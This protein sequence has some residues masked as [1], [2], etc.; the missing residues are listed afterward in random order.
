MTKALA[1]IAACEADPA[2]VRE[3]SEAD[4]DEMYATAMLLIG[5][6]QLLPVIRSGMIEPRLKISPTGDLI[7]ERGTVQKLLEPSAAWTNG[8]SL[9][10]AAAAYVS[11]RS[12]ATTDDPPPVWDAGLRAA[13][14]AEY[15]IAAEPYVN[16]PHF[17]GRMAEDRGQDVFFERLS[18]IERL[19]QDSADYAG[20]KVRPLLDRLT[21]RTRANWGD[22]LSEA[23]RDLCRF[24]RN[25]SLISRPLLM[26]EDGADP[27]IL[28]AP[29]LV[30][31]AMMFAVSGLATGHLNNAFWQS[32]AARRCA[33]ER[34][35]ASKEQFEE[36]VAARLN[37]LGLSA[38]ARCKLSTVLNQKVDPELG[39]VDV[40]AVKAEH[41][42]VWVIEAKNLR[43][44]RTEP[45]VASPLSEYQERWLGKSGQGR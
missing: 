6:G 44:C 2:G 31:D 45:E 42:T 8:K 37:E 20:I 5:N 25:H 13:I 17:L 35:K 38:T 27:L 22:G 10:E 16:L 1:E 12:D 23:E 7:S 34:G 39:D 29:A 21:L 28:V 41:S 15:Q 36:T 4:L 40:L 32:D 11:D 14:E 9:D 30:Y 43:L 18:A 33:G 19:L 24:D 3:P 26:V